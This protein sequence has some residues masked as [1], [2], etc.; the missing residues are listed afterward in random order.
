M[1]FKPEQKIEMMRSDGTMSPGCI[2]GKGW[3]GRFGPTYK[4][5]L[6]EGGTKAAVT[7]DDIINQV[8]VYDTKKLAKAVP[9]TKQCT[10]SCTQC[11]GLKFKPDQNVEVVRSDGAMSPGYI[12]GKGRE[13]FDGP[14]YK[15][16]LDDGMCKQAV[17]EEEI[18]DEVRM[19]WLLGGWVGKAA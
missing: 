4:V 16:Q 11:D 19:S 7:E 18:S 9:C 3:P 10:A 12:V 8:T 6:D 13:G 15:V 2:V 14:T 1:K 17:P 5:L